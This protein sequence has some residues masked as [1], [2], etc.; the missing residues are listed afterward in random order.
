[1]TRDDLIG[2]VTEA[3]RDPRRNAQRIAAWDVPMPQVWS[4]LL[5][6]SVLAVLGLYAAVLISGSLGIMGPLPAPFALLVVQVAAMLVLAAM[7]ARIG[8]MFGGTGSFD[9]ALRVTVWLQALMV[10]MQLAQLVAMLV[11]PPLAGLV[12]LA[13][14]VGV[15]WL[16]SGMVA[17]LHGFRSQV[18]TLLGILGSF[19][20]LGL[21]L[22]VVLAFFLPTVQ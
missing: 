13:S 18:V 7:M 6:V 1:M 10:L 14:V 3:L 8:R 20:A 5:L 17:G 12:S 9:G 11:L 22:S 2:L 19:L 21:A 4:A 15:G 16:A